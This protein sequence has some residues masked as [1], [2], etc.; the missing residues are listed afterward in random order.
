MTRTKTKV[1]LLLQALIPKGHPRFQDKEGDRTDND[2]FNPPDHSL[3]GREARPKMGSINQMPPFS[4]GRE[5]S[6]PTG[7]IPSRQTNDRLHHR[8]RHHQQDTPLNDGAHVEAMGQSIQDLRGCFGG[9]RP[10]STDDDQARGAHGQ[11]VGYH[12]GLDGNGGI[13]SGSAHGQQVRRDGNGGFPWGAPMA[14]KFTAMIQGTIDTP[15][16]EVFPEM[17]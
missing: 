8:Q 14:N 13:P 15:I 4:R 16:M 1:L 7:E 17:T 9:G 3:V 10:T 5:G 12:I 11:P 6:L 2:K